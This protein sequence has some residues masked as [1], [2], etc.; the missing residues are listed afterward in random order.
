MP[1]TLGEGNDFFRWLFLQ[2][3]K[4]EDATTD[5]QV[6]AITPRRSGPSPSQ[7]IDEA[8]V[9][10]RSKHSRQP[11]P[12]DDSAIVSRA[13]QGHTTKGENLTDVAYI[14]LIRSMSNS[15]RRRTPQLVIEDTHANRLANYPAS[16]YAVGTLFWETDRTVY[17]LNSGAAGSQYWLYTAGTCY[18]T[19]A[20]I[21]GD[22]GT[23]DVGFLNSVTDY[24]HVIEW[25]GTGFIWGPGEAGSGFLQ[26]FEVDPTGAGWHLYD[27]STVSYLKS[28]GSLGSIA[29]PNLSG[30]APT[31][32]YLKTSDTNAGP[33]APTA[34]TFTGSG[35]GFTGTPATLTGNVAAPVFTGAALGTHQ[36]DVPIGANS[37][38]LELGVPFGTG[39]LQT[40]NVQAA[41]SA[42][43]ASFNCVKTQAV[44]AGTPAGTNNAPA[45]TMD[46]YTPA[47]TVTG[48]GS[49]GTNGEPENLTRRAFFRQ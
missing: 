10:G 5:Q 9:L 17:Y 39:S 8:V 1:Q 30:A 34:P 6:R 43:S 12:L 29:L 27:G 7:I 26:L 23:H 32:S 13:V 4:V 44:P 33:T 20:L 25:N 15:G 36:H 35:F 42:S 48:S 18:T 3:R 21:P 31:R 41:G 37:S 16:S 22:L 47:G 46:S 38:T 45:L 11:P 28:D 24:G 40:A 19:Q 49:I 2:W 14:A